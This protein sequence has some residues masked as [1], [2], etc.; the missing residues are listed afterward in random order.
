MVGVIYFGSF[1]N[2][3]VGRADALAMNERGQQYLQDAAAL[4]A[5]A[6]PHA[7][8]PKVRVLQIQ[9]RVTEQKGTIF[10]EEQ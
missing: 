1:P 10:P 8:I 3:D 5:A 6:V 4:G 7:A 9:Q 2:T